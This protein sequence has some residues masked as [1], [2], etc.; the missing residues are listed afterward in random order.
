MAT[1][2]T[3][4]IGA[5]SPPVGAQRPRCG[6][7]SF[8]DRAWPSQRV[9]GTSH[10][11]GSRRS[12]TLPSTTTGAPHG[13]SRELP[14]D[15]D[16][17]HAGRCRCVP[18]EPEGHRSVQVG[19][20]G[21]ADLL[22]P[23]AVL[24]ETRG[25]FWGRGRRSRAVVRVDARDE[26]DV[27]AA[28]VGQFPVPGSIRTASCPRSTA[29]SPARAEKMPGIVGREA[30]LRRPDAVR[31]SG[32]AIPDHAEYRG[33]HESLPAITRSRRIRNPGSRGVARSAM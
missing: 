13:C 12:S 3:L 11:A 24:A 1:G 17:R 25:S 31:L 33:R 5:R 8:S 22:D 7:A 23:V 27:E 15:S 6:L 28:R 19:L 20:V 9:T 29:S 26:F 21:R 16:V 14:G 30:T 4:A 18:A 2:L 10:P 32:R